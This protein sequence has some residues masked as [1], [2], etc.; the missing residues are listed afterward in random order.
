MDAPE[1]VKH[2]IIEG[3]DVRWC[4]VGAA[5]GAVFAEE[6]IL[7]SMEIVFD[8]PVIPVEAQQLFRRSLIARQAGYEEDDFLFRRLPHVV[9]FAA[10]RTPDTADLPDGRPCIGRQG[11]S[12]Q[13]VN[14]ALLD[15]AVRFFDG[16]GPCLRGKK[17]AL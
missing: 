12:G 8:R 10:A 2:K 7:V 17:S 11:C 14:A 5:G 9:L 4:V 16:R 6:V 3:C 1:Q 15:P 13:N